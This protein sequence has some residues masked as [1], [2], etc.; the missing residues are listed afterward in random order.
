MSARQLA[1]KVTGTRPVR[2]LGDQATALFEVSI[3]VPTVELFVQSG[4][5]LIDARYADPVEAPVL[6]QA[7]K[8]AADTAMARDVLA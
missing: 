8:L 7:G 4:N 6:S 3:T 1:D 5:M 2:G